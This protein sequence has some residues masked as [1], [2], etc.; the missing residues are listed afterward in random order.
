M[1]FLFLIVGVALLGAV[2]V[3][4]DIIEAAWL[5]REI[6]WG[7]ALVLLVYGAAFLCDTISWLIATPAMPLNARW[8]GRFFAVRMAGESF[9]T[10]LPAAGMGG[11]PV[12]ALMLKR[13]YGVA[14]QD[15]IAS[16]ILARTIN[17]IALVLFLAGGFVLI[18]ASPQLSGAYKELSGTGLA[19]FA[20]GVVL[21]IALQRYKVT[22]LAGTALSRAH[23][24]RKLEDVLH[25]LHAVEDRLVHFYTERRGRLTGALALSLLNWSLGV[26]EIYVVMW[27]LG[28]PVSF[29]D[30]WII[31]GV[32]QLVR[33]ATFVIPASIGAQEGAFLVIG[34]A[35]TGQPSLA[36]AMALVRRI[37]EIA[38]AALGFV[39]FYVL[40]PNMPEVTGDAKA[41]ASDR[42]SD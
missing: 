27:L 11:E 33:T 25:H 26:A 7:L 2:L 23:W 20:L 10:A 19:A 24:F 3:E 35:I 41:P 14:Y 6:G 1:K 13:M 36:L 32:T 16:L 28:Q 30:A 34:S 15:S 17:V 5:V 12:K 22:S 39:M 18:L 9:N 40:K 4:T 42:P 29:T 8:V 31:E 21:L 37:R 38:W